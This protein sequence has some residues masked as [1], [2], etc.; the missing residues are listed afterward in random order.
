MKEENIK[1]VSNTVLI[2]WAARKKKICMI[3]EKYQLE[4]WYEI[5]R[6]STLCSAIHILCKY[7]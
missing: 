3:F 6:N 1:F 5:V 2:N 4:F 7:I